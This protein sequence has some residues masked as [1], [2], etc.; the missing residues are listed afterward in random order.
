MPVDL[1]IGI[2]LGMTYTG[3]FHLL[4]MGDKCRLHLDIKCRRI[5]H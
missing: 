4:S 1:I 3:K 5:G 2:D